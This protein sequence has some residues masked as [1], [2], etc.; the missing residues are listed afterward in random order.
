LVGAPRGLLQGNHRSSWGWLVA[1]VAELTGDKD[2]TTTKMMA[3][4]AR[5]QVEAKPQWRHHLL[6][7][8]Q[9]KGEDGG[10]SKAHLLR[11]IERK[12]PR[13]PLT[14]RAGRVQERP[15]G[16]QCF[17]VTTPTKCR[18]QAPMRARS[19]AARTSA[20]VSAHLLTQVS[21]AYRALT[22]VDL[23]GDYRCR[24]AEVSV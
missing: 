22:R 2:P 17:T 11:K 21:E 20:S 7:S 15:R 5:A 6:S 8:L 4:N 19:P 18:S 14:L 9:C 1:T 23:W 13:H 16:R 3:E 12:A 10:N 24:R